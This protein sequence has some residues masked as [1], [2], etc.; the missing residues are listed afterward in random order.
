M[1]DGFATASMLVF[2][3]LIVAT[4][5]VLAVLI[6]NRQHRDYRTRDLLTMSL[7]SLLDLL[8]FK[9]IIL[10]AGLKGSI[11]FLKGKK[12]WDKFERNVRASPRS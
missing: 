7:Y 11:D 5:S 4:P 6:D 12:G 8:L 10:V 1:L 3:G 2:A 9:P